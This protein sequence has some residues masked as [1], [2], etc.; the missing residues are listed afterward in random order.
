MHSVHDYLTAWQYCSG[1]PHNAMRRHD[2]SLSVLLV[3]KQRP[4]HIG[5]NSQ[6][7]HQM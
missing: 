6:A 1:L 5:E 7:G 2:V 3:P 4:Y